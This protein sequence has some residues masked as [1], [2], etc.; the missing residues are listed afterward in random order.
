MSGDAASAAGYAA[1]R[2]RIDAALRRRAF[3]VVPS[4]VAFATLGDIIAAA[5]LQRGRFQAADSLY[6]WGILAGSSVGLLATT[7]ARLYSAAHYALGDTKRPLRFALVRLAAVTTLGYPCAI[8][9][10]PP[11][12]LPPSLA[13]AAPTALPPPPP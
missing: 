4:A 12:S 9:L 7:M 3:F 10:P 2:A 8:P 5:L 1:L 11:P 13:A 6:V